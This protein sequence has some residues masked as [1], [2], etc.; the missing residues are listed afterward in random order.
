ME[1][2]RPLLKE[3]RRN[4]ERNI[5]LDCSLKSIHNIFRQAQ[6]VGMM[7]LAQSYFITS[8]VSSF[9]HSIKHV[10]EIM[11]FMKLIQSIILNCLTQFKLLINCTIN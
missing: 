3:M 11:K 9:T 5:V 8:L 6:E 7:S 2:L 1:L 4:G 10:K